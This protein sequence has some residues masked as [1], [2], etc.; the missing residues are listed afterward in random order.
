MHSA[1]QH[2][3]ISLQEAHMN[4]KKQQYSFPTLGSAICLDALTFFLMELGVSPPPEAN[5]TTF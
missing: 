1:P 3:H 2:L 4:T 5:T